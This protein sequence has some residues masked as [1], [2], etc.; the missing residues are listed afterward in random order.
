MEFSKMPLKG[1]GGSTNQHVVLD[2]VQ[3]FGSFDSALTTWI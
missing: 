2:L 1:G 3:F